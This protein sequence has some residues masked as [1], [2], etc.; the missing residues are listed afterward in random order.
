MAKPL[1][2][3][4]DKIFAT[5]QLK[6]TDYE[7]TDEEP[8][9]DGRVTKWNFM[10]GKLLQEF[11]GLF[12]KEINGIWY[13]NRLNMRIAASLK[14]SQKLER[15]RYC[16]PELL[17]RAHNSN[18]TINVKFVV[19]L[20]NCRKNNTYEQYVALE[21]VDHDPEFRPKISKMYE[22]HN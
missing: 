17:E 12:V 9:E 22:V 18:M 7:K 10:I 2:E 11:M 8:C 5:R 15:V 14:H 20:G 16:A 19:T 3:Q 6:I 4:I 1:D 13:L 21:A